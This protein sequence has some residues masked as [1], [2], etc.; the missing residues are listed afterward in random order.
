[1]N[2]TLAKLI[3]SV[4]LL[5]P[6]LIQPAL[7]Q[8]FEKARIA[9]VDMQQIMNELAVVKDVNAQLKQL[10]DKAL[11]ELDAEEARLKEE[12]AQIERQKLLVTPEAYTEKQAAFNRKIAEYRA[13]T[14]DRAMQI[15]RTRVNSLNKVREQML[16][17]MRDIVNEYG[18]TVVL[19]MSEVLFAEKPLNLTE[20]VIE[21]LN[22]RL[23]KIKVELAPVKKS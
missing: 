12:R 8:Q 13:K 10:E 1:M 20:V 15:Q 19:D 22:K 14:N 6:A 5:F 9:V 17:L 18:A 2:S 7:A 16:P 11:A 3:L 21:R 23:S 4:F